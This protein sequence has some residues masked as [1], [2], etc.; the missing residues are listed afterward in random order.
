MSK[1]KTKNTVVIVWFFIMFLQMGGI[2]HIWM[3]AIYER[4]TL[5]SR[6]HVN[7]ACNFKAD[8]RLC[9]YFPRAH[10]SSI[11]DLLDIFLSRWFKESLRGML[12]RVIFHPLN[13]CNWQ[14][15]LKVEWMCLA[16]LWQVRVK[17]KQAKTAART[18]FLI[19]MFALVLRCLLFCIEWLV[20]TTDLYFWLD[21]SVHVNE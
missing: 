6:A 10:G 14:A 8:M 7:C 15:T 13:A 21:I 16:V 12:S 3:Q 11:S 9:S 4:L 1:K 5:S 20:W 18:E 17:I 19:Y 2:L